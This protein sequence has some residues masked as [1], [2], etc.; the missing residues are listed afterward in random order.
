MINN[1]FY[2]IIPLLITLFFL[3]IV[4]NFAFK[5]KISDE[6]DNRKQK[7]IKMIRIGG[8]SFVLAYLISIFIF[9][10]F[11]LNGSGISFDDDLI[12]IIFLGSVGY[13]LIGIS[14][15]LFSVSPFIRLFFQGIVA[16]C[17][18]NRF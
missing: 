10:Y 17:V 13:F 5:N 14:D 8:I 3:P 11:Q 12:R 16:F 18:A 6:P 9:I 1:I 2:F 4:K 15:D 7:K